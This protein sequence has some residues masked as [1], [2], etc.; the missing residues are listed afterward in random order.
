MRVVRNTRTRSAGI[1]ILKPSDEVVAAQ[2]L[3]MIHEACEEW[4]RQPRAKDAKASA[5]VPRRVVRETVKAILATA[6]SGREPVYV[7]KAAREWRRAAG[8]IA[9]SMPDVVAAFRD[10]TPAQIRYLT[11]GTGIAPPQR[12]MG[13]PFARTEAIPDRRCA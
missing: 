6:S 1:L 12:P 13:V 4:L 3:R 2:R 10:P 9:A 11:R 8:K 5:V 7:L